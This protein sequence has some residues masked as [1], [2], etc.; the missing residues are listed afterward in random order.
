LATDL[1]MEPVSQATDGVSRERRQQAILESAV[2]FAIIAT[3][4][5]GRVTDWNRGA[6]LIFGWSAQEACG[7]AVDRIFTAEDREHGVPAENLRRALEVGRSAGDRW[8]PRKAG[9]RFWASGVTTPLREPDGGHIGFL[10]VLRDRTEARADRLRLDSSEARLALALSVGG[11]VGAW[12]WDMRT[13]LVHADTNF[14]HLYSVDPEAAARGASPETYTR[15]FHPDDLPAYEAELARA[16]AEDDEFSSEYRILQPDGTMRRVLARGRV[17]R[18]DDGTPV[19]FPGATV[20]VT[21][22]RDAEETLRITQRAGGVGTFVIYPEVGMLEASAELYHMFGVPHREGL[23]PMGEM[24]EYVLPEDRPRVR[25]DG[26]VLLEAGHAEVEYRIRRPRDGQ[27]RWI[28]RRAQAIG[29]GRSQR[30]LGVVQDITDRKVAED[31]LRTSETQFRTLAQTT[32][33][34]V[35]IARLDGLIDWFNDRAYDY[36][37]MAPGALEG[38]GCLAMIHPED[39]QAVTARWAQV[40][41]SGKA[42]ETELRLRRA[43]G[44]YRWYLSRATPI[45]GADGELTHWIGSN[46]DIE[47]Q[48]A[49]ALVLADLNATLEARM[50][51]RT[52]ELMAAEEALR[53]AQK[54]EAVGQLTGGIAHDF[55]NLLQ[56]ITGS[57]DLVRKRIAQ[58]RLGELER[59][60]TGAM[61]S[62]DR[63]AALTHR[64]LAF[65]R[66]QPLDP[67]PVRVNPLVASMEDL[68]RRSLGEQF[69]LELVLAG[70]LWLTLCDANQ[71]ENALLNLA[72]NARDA[73]PGGGRLT[74]ETCNAH[75]DSDYAARQRE[76]KPG[77]YVCV[78]VT[79]TGVGM[80]AATMAKAFDPFFTTKPLGQGTGLGLSMIYGFARQSE[81]HAKIY[82]EVGQGTTFKLYLPRHLGPVEE[83]EIRRRALPPAL[84]SERGETVL[85]V[86]DEAVLRGLIAEVLGDLGYQA[87]EAATGPDGLAILQSER[88]IDLLITD[89]GLPGLNGRQLVD[90]ARALRPELRVLFMTGYA[91]NAAVASGFLEPGMAMITKPFAMDALATRISEALRAR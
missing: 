5:G 67:R 54:M 24:V 37:G 53:Q 85:V 1:D 75:L 38:A 87:L 13:N 4:R 60:I 2:D 57:L 20:D 88:R 10:T 25:A 56:G 21:A 62:A 3:D 49:A 81:G 47:D 12:D 36:S 31:K 66:R 82:S 55:N 29:E 34:Q 44:V 30:I 48:K 11:V 6:E 18:D 64:L 89:I 45:H 42:Y 8:R 15:Q 72:I 71:L 77:Q 46:T 17:M 32:P 91:E 26:A 69:N 70:G 65:S 86:E 28:G 19:R 73:M 52:G 27:V 40:R 43:D 68:L 41:A 80:D 39:A 16:L 61:T 76:V 22:L 59:F 35:W 84:A 33:N 14:A 7:G 63:A 23:R 74:I 50:A 51:E 90:A 9:N 58:G 78:S 79:D 83:E